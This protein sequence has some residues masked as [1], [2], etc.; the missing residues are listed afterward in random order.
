MPH[1]E[2]CSFGAVR[3]DDDVPIGHRTTLNAIPAEHLLGIREL[4]GVLDEEA[5]LTD[6]LVGALRGDLGRAL[7]TLLGVGDFLF[8]LLVLLLVLDDE[9]VLQDDVEAGLY[10]VGVEV[11]FVL[12]L[13]VLLVGGGRLG[14]ARSSAALL[15]LLALDDVVV[16]DGDV[17]IV[18]V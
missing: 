9:A 11:L 14:L 7:G 1:R 17:V 6:E 18:L 5:G 16:V 3:A 10:I 4:A 13:L 15:F 8:L 12:F 2:F